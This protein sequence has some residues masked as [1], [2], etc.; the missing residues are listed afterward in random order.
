MPFFNLLFQAL[1]PAGGKMLSSPVFLSFASSFVNKQN[2][3]VQIKDKLFC[4]LAGNSLYDL[5]TLFHTSCLCLLPPP[6]SPEK[7]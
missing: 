7:K 3:N 4:N 5:A 2:K 6:P 1:L